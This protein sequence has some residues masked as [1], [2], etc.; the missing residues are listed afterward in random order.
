VEDNEESGQLVDVEAIELEQMADVDCVRP[1]S[2][3]E[4]A[5]R[6]RSRSRRG[7]YTRD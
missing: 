1:K 6:E 2:L 7:R 5:R 4:S 3:S